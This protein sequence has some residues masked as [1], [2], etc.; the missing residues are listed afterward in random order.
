M[1]TFIYLFVYLF[2]YGSFVLPWVFPVVADSGLYSKWGLSWVVLPFPDNLSFKV[3]PVPQIKLS[4]P[5]ALRQG[6][7]LSF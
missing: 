7:V 4:G 5:A 3:L 2:S 6:L 1:L